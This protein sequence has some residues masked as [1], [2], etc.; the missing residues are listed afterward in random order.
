MTKSMRFRAT[1]VTAPEFE[2]PD[3]KNI[4][5]ELAAVGGES[6]GH[7]FGVGKIARA[8]G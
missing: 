6:G 4:S 1:V 8:I 2:L 7:R 3:Y 5:V